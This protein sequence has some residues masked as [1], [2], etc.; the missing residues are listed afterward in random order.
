MIVVNADLLDGVSA[1][2]AGSAGQRKNLNFHTSSSDLLQRML[3]AVEPG[4]Y[5][6][7][8]KHEDPDKREV[9]VILRGRV[10][11]VEFNAEGELTGHTILDPD[12]GNYA[13][14]IAPRV[15]HALYSLAPGSVVYEVKDGPYSPHDDKHFATWAPREGA[16]ECKDYLDNLLLKIQYLDKNQ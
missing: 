8:H 11:V 1:Q 3:N 13:V 6:C 16:P 15:Y 4:T 2:A 12:A 10:L 5:V 9:F 7:P 14:E